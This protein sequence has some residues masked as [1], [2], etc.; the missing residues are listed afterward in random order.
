MLCTLE[1]VPSYLHWNDRPVLVNDAF[2]KEHIL[3]RITEDGNPVEVPNTIAEYSCKWGFI[4]NQ[5][6]LLKVDS[7]PLGNSFKYAYIET[8]LNNLLFKQKKEDG[9]FQGWHKLTCSFSHKPNPCDYS[10]CVIDIIHQ[11]F[12]EDEQKLLYTEVS[13]YE[14]WAEKKALLSKKGQFYSKLRGDYRLGLIKTFF[15]PQ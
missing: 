4:I 14:L 15:L 12:D 11:V 5:E 7:P 1:N 3:Y 8:I 13:S 6:D 10:H 9:D 2:L